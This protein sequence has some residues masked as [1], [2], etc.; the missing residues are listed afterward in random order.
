MMFARMLILVCLIGQFGYARTLKIE[1][2]ID[3]SATQQ[4][5]ISSPIKIAVISSPKV[6]GKYSQSVFNVSLA[7]L[8]SLTAGEC[9][10]KHYP[11][12]EESSNALSKTMTEIYHDDMGAILAPLTASGT[13]NFLA[14]NPKLPVFIPTVHKRDFSYA[15]Q[16]VAFGSIDYVRQIEA[17]LP[18]MSDSIAVFYDDSSVGK[19][20]KASTEEAFL[21]YKGAKKTFTAYAVDQKGDNIVSHLSKPSQFHKKSIIFHLPVVKSSLLAAHLTFT[22]VKERN[23]LSTQINIDPNLLN[24][25]QYHDRKNMILANSL[26]EFPAAIYESNALMNNDI[27]FDWVNYAAS[28]GIDYLVAVVNGTPR[29]YTMRIINN[30]VI[31]PIEL[32]RPKESGFEPLNP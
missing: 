7:T 6:I 26:I 30:Q 19:Q 23:I 18:Y 15:P 27:S 10:I 22:G 21:E 24:L 5:H 8:I 32:L 14:L 20:L 31:Y 25:T 17:L 16:N 13:K 11:L 29:A 1:K 3:P 12:A 28:V 9:E 2:S 4:S